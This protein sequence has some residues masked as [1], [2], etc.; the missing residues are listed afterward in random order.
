MSIFRVKVHLERLRQDVF[1]SSRMPQSAHEMS[2]YDN[3]E[4]FEL[5][6]DFDDPVYV[7]YRTSPQ[8]S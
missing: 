8:F 5:D 4:K 2:H 7:V 6:G 3:T 1:W